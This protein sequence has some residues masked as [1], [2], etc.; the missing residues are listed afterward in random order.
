[1]KNSNFVK[2]HLL[3][4]QFF[5]R[6]VLLSTIIFSII[7][8]TSCSSKELSRSQAQKLI[9]ETVN[10]K[11][12]FTLP[13]VQ[14]KAAVAGQGSLRILEERTETP[15]EAEQRKIKL[16]LEMF[17][18]VAVANHLGLVEP[19]VK[20]H[21][22]EQPRHERWMDGPTWWFDEKYVTTDQAKALWKEY[23]LP[24]S[25]D[26]IPLAG[27]EFTEVTGI[28]KQGGDAAQAQFAWKYVPNETSRYFDGSTA[29]FKTLPADI[30]ERM[31][32]KQPPTI[33][34]R[35][36]EDQTTKF[37]INAR[38]GAATFRRY[39]DGWRLETVGFYD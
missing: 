8:T 23:D 27:K 20:S 13:L 9:E 10:F 24:P 14:G 38:Q 6:T 26:S 33:L 16:Y 5:C 15:S 19:R 18:P 37:S 30:R 32:G 4:F 12:P 7:S 35:A 1:M 28:T 3:G 17:P 2:L 29:E 34:V 21:D 25:E 22:S 31:L 11:Q 36:P 39:D